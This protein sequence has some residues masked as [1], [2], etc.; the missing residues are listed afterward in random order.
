MMFNEHVSLPQKSLIFQGFIL[1]WT[2]KYE[3]LCPF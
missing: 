3:P 2:K 1:E